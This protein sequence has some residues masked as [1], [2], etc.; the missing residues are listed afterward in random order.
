MQRSVLLQIL[1]L[2]FLVTKK[3]HKVEDFAWTG[4][5]DSVALEHALSRPPSPPPSLSL[6]LALMRS[7]AHLNVRAIIADVYNS[8]E[9]S[10][11]LQAALCRGLVTGMIFQSQGRTLSFSG[12][13]WTKRR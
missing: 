1:L 2:L 4:L 7:L 8:N 3:N 9:S 13:R 6:S 10:Y 12:A 5:S 11:L